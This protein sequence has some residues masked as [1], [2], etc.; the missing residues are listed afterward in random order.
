MEEKNLR[1]LAFEL[2]EIVNSII[3]NVHT[4]KDVEDELYK[5]RDEMDSIELN[6]NKDTSDLIAG[7]L[8]FLELHKPVRI[9]NDLL[10]YSVNDLKEN[11]EICRK[12]AD[13]V[14]KKVVKEEAK[15]IDSRN[16]DFQ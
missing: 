5:I 7:L 9:I 8:K 12:T 15:V 10:Y 14:F 11:C 2:D 16:N 13:M 1:D 3:A 6:I 4:L